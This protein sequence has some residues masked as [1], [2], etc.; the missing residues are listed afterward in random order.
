VKFLFRSFHLLQLLFLLGVAFSCGG[1]ITLPL[2]AVT[3]SSQGG[4]VKVHLEAFPSQNTQALVSIPPYY[5]VDLQRSITDA[6]DYIGMD[7]CTVVVRFDPSTNYMEGP[8]AGA[9]F[10]VALYALKNNVSFVNSPIITG[11]LGPGGSVM[12]VGGLYEKAMAASRS[13]SG[14]FIYP[15]G[16]VYDYVMLKQVEKKTNMK[17]IIVENIEEILDFMIENKTP[18]EKKAVSYLPEAGKIEAYEESS[19]PDFVPIAKKMISRAAEA[20]AELQKAGSEQWISEYYSGLLEDSGELLKKGYVYTAANNAFLAY[21]DI[22]TLGFIYSGQPSY[23]QEKRSVSACVSGLERPV[24]TKENTE[25][26]IAFDLRK[27]WAE[28]NLE[29]SNL[30]EKH[31]V[32]EEQI[33]YRDLVYAEAWCLAAKDFAE[34]ANEK[35][36]KTENPGILDESVFVDTATKYMEKANST[37]HGADTKRRFEIAKKL[38]DEGKYGAA[39]FDFAYV[40]SMD[41]STAELASMSDDEIKQ[42]LQEMEQTSLGFMWPNIYKSQA[43]F[44]ANGE[45]PNY[46][47]AFSLFVFSEELDKA[48][49]EMAAAENAKA[50]AARP[51]EPNP[52]QTQNGQL[53]CDF[54]LIGVAT[55]AIAAIFILF[56]VV[57]LYIL[58]KIKR[59]SYEGKHKP[60]RRASG[61]EGEHRVKDRLPERKKTR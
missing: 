32:E 13:G 19:Q 57:L 16:S 54:V 52:Q 2:A 30:S 49:K 27:A 12:P 25:L 8:S 15:K 40:V 34:V 59:R 61:R 6:I 42:R 17:V 14:I 24:M 60:S 45:N 46:G 39:I 55:A 44:L 51:A 35:N 18:S 23:Q 58:P 50:S 29:K 56:V 26:V 10:A 47:A 9:A 5:G 4:V 20:E 53:N 3:D 31:L 22:K 37:T 33:S 48:L 1:N 11:A 36:T 21:V 7:N 41:E 38:Y 28:D 43:V